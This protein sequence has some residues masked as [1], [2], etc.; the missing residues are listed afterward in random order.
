M[1]FGRKLKLFAFI[2]HLL[3]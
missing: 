1:K 2:L 3:A